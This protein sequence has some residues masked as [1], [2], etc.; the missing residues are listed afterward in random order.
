MSLTLFF[1]INFK[2]A[3]SYTSPKSGKTCY[4]THHREAGTRKAEIFASMYGTV[5]TVDVKS[6]H[7]LPNLVLNAI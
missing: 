1:G 5:E 7:E 3:H 6:I 2:Y 4:F